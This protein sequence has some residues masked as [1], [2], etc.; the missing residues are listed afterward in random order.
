MTHRRRLAGTVHH[1]S[2]LALVA[3][4]AALPVTALVVERPAAADLWPGTNILLASAA[5]LG[6]A[7]CL[8][9][10]V[11]WVR[12]RWNSAE[13][14]PMRLAFCALTLGALLILA[15]GQPV[16]P[17]RVANLYGRVSGIF[18]LVLAGGPWIAR[19]LPRGLARLSDLALFNVCLTLVLVEATARLYGS[20]SWSPLFAT[21]DVTVEDHMAQWRFAPGTVH[22]GYPV[23]EKGYVDR[24]EPRA[25]GE[26]LVVSIGDSFAFCFVSNDFHYTSVCERELSGIQFYNIG[27]RCVGPLAYHRMMIEDAL[28]LKPDAILIGLFVGND[29]WDMAEGR[30]D[31]PHAWLRRIFDRRNLLLLNLPQRLVRLNRALS[32]AEGYGDTVTSTADHRAEPMSIAEQRRHFRY[33]WDYALEWPAMSLESY[34][35]LER[36]IANNVCTGATEPYDALLQEMGAIKKRAGDTPVYAIVLPDEFQV[37]DEVWQQVRCL[38]REQDG[39]ENPDRDQP[40]RI[41]MQGL[42]RLGIP[43]VDVLQALR[44]VP[45]EPDGRR[46]LYHLQ[47]T[48]FNLR[49]CRATGKAL[50]GFLNRELGLPRLVAVEISPKPA[51]I[52]DP[53]RGAALAIQGRFSDGQLRR[54]DPEL[55]DTVRSSDPSTIAV[56]RDGS[57]F[58]LRQGRIR[59]LVDYQGH[60]AQTDIVARWDSVLEVSPGIA[61]SRGV[62][63]RLEACGGVPERGNRSFGLRLRDTSERSA[64]LL[65]VS[66]LPR[67]DLDA[68][69]QVVV[70]VPFRGASDPL[71][72]SVL[73]FPI[74]S[75]PR[76]AGASVF[77]VAAVADPGAP[78][79]FSVSNGLVITVE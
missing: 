33:W 75:D 15:F 11:A 79:G 70:P 54:L 67:F 36:R 14:W 29:T 73:P 9:R 62:V 31:K 46:H 59:L 37:E 69:P 60:R 68:W 72:G 55:I 58:P 28:P 42:A 12:G 38:L 45:L 51:L 41:L 78:L 16:E 52:E 40:Q 6:C 10:A 3:A 27:I 35:D 23:D 17:Y 2:Y 26:Q 71:G 18:F 25:E 7:V 19:R 44:A 1:A 49:G 43:A 20:V 61:G 13:L 4:F 21:G 5:L 66:S 34:L 8:S 47:D 32:G 74:P 76:H 24:L 65:F 77:V 63:P 22:F 39:V 56:G 50:A 48:H 30:P 64:G 57:V 53:T